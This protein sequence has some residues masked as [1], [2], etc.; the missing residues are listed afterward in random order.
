MRI[1]IT[2]ARGL[3][4]QHFFNK[5]STS[6]TVVGIDREE[7][8]LRN[9]LV[10]SY[11]LDEYKPD[12][13]LHLAA[14]VGRIFGENNVMETV[15]DNA[16]MTAVVA[17]ACGNADVKLAYASTSEIYGD[18]G[19]EWATE[20]SPT[21]NILP[22]N[23]YGM[24]KR[25]GEEVS[26]LYAPKGLLIFRFGMPIGR[27]YLP[28]VGKAAIATFIWNAMKKKPIIVHRDTERSWC[29]VGDIASAVKTV[30]EAAG[31]D[32]KNCGVWNIGRDDNLFTMEEIANRICE[33]VKAPK[34]L[35]HLVDPP[36]DVTRKKRQ[37]TQRL[38]DLGWKP[39]VSFDEAL[40]WTYRWLQ[41]YDQE[42]G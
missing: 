20:D 4:G 13:V 23:L 17:K 7:G 42:H 6:H 18:F 38:R 1:L 32:E 21:M 16:G 2:G 14:K 29:W 36:P 39:E 3:L 19:E 33:M 8:D 34:S 9:P 25:W 26:R 15:T 12:Y 10:I 5:L 28:G 40:L 30:M 31:A 22:R 35:I 37:S 11:Y 24:S 41:E 27:G